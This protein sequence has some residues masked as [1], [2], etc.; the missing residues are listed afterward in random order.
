MWSVMLPVGNGEPMSAS[1]TS[2][3]M[4]RTTRKSFPTTKWASELFL[5][6]F[7]GQA[8]ELGLLLQIARDA[9]VKWASHFALGNCVRCERRIGVVGQE[10]VPGAGVEFSRAREIVDLL[11][12]RKRLAKVVAVLAV[13]FTRRE[14]VAVEQHLGFDDQRRVTAA[15]LW[16]R[17]IDGF[18]RFRRGWGWRS[19]LNVSMGRRVGNRKR[20]RYY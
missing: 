3:S 18:G 17:R 8:L 13:D 2:F 14:A 16:R 20:Q 10:R 7:V 5:R 12:S 4:R 1:A 15:A 19:V 11:E 9:F 6:S